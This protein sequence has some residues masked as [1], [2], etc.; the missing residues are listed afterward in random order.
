MFYKLHLLKALRGINFKY[1]NCTASTNAVAK[2]YSKTA[3]TDCLFIAKTQTKGKGKGERKFVSND[4]GL[5]FTI[6]CKKVDFSPSFALKTVINAGLS[7]YGVLKQLGFDAK[8]KWPNDVLV[9][10]SKI[11]GIL[12]EKADNDFWIMGIGINIVS[13]PEL[14]DANYKTTSLKNLGTNVDRIQVLEYFVRVFNEL[15]KEFQNTG[16]NNIRQTWLDNAYNLGNSVIIKQE[17]ESIEGVFST[18]DEYGRI[19]LETKDGLKSIIVGD[20]LVKES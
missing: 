4:G 18:I 10:D 12:F 3:K 2:E 11:S 9:N 5:Y 1:Y 14:L 8:L 6:F 17:T 7:V 19:V 16:F 15:L 13:N 20:L